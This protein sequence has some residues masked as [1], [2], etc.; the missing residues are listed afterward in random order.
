MKVLQVEPWTFLDARKNP[1]EGYK[2]TFQTDSGQVGTVDIAK[3]D[4]TPEK[5]ADQVGE[6][7]AKIDQVMSL[8]TER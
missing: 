2:V 1:V 5:V 8:T 6:E 4:F 3:A 7:A